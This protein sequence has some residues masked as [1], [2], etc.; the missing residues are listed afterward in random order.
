MSDDTIITTHRLRL[1]TWR[2]TDAAPYGLHCNTQPVMEHLG[3]V[4]SQRAVSQDVTWFSKDH[5]RH[6]HS[7]WAMERKRDLLFLGFCGF[8]RVREKNS[9]LDGELEIGWRL[10]SDMWR[11]GY[12]REAAEAVIDWA[13]W[14]FDGD[15]LYARVHPENEASQGLA[16]ALGMRRARAMER[17]L[18]SGDGECV[19]F[20]LKL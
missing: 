11:R 8:I 13:G 7:F 2:D 14:E 12:A 20:R 5:Q 18:R 15:W 16:K 6:D 1:R 17:K 9:A 3:G 19:V 4:V 10:R